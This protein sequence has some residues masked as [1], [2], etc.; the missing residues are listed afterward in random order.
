MNSLEF[1][2]LMLMADEAMRI[3]GIEKD[4]EKECFVKDDIEI[5]WYTM[6]STLANEGIEGVGKILG[7]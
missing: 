7:E 6:Y 2:V 4:Y 5:D 3:Y 1:E